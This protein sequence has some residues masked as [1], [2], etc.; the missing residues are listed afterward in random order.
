MWTVAD[1]PRARIV[2]PPIDSAS[3]FTHVE[4]NASKGPIRYS[5]D[6]E[7]CI[8]GPPKVLG[9]LKAGIHTLQVWAGDDNAPALASWRQSKAPSFGSAEIQVGVDE[10]GEHTLMPTPPIRWGC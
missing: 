3:P 1:S 2:I 6:G 7:A 9:P 10:E 5:I 4:V 8:E